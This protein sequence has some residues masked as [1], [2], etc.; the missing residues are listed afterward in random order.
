[1]MTFATP[2]GPR[3]D[4]EKT[5]LDDARA[6]FQ[7][8]A[9]QRMQL[10]NFFILATAFLVTAYGQAVREQRELLATG[11]A[12]L[13]FVIAVGFLLLEFRTEQLVTR[14]RQAMSHLQA[15]LSQR[16]AIPQ[17]H[18]FNPSQDGQLLL[19][20]RIIPTLYSLVAIAFFVGACAPDVFERTRGPER[21]AFRVVGR[22]VEVQ[23]PRAGYS[24]WVPVGRAA[25]VQ[26]S[27]GTA[28][29]TSETEVAALI[30]RFRVSLAGSPFDGG[31]IDILVSARCFDALAVGEHWPSGR[32]E[33]D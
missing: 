13:G 3:T 12:S 15:R 31:G 7:T 16:V 22:V 24:G 10:V 21:A 25:V 19:Y 5:A 27:N 9:A 26:D 14:G 8:Q 28:S 33:C 1:M 17:V 23:A 11:I 30:A 20:R 29:L 4:D 6:I 18:Q 32:S 2:L